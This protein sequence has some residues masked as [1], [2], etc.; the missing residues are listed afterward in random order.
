M[1]SRIVSSI[2]FHKISYDERGALGQEGGSGVVVRKFPRMLK[3]L[4]LKSALFFTDGCGSAAF[5]S[6]NLSNDV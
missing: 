4:S 5:W 3:I 1:E 2:S 6:F